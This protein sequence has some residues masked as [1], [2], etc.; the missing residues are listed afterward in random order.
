MG[1][2][3]IEESKGRGDGSLGENDSRSVTTLQHD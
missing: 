3:K 1:M 2:N